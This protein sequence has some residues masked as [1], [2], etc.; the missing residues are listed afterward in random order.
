MIRKH[1]KYRITRLIVLMHAAPKN[2]IGNIQSH[3]M[4]QVTRH[5]PHQLVEMLG[6]QH[7]TK[8]MIETKFQNLALRLH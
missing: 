5:E 6:D 1:G 3:R 7:E 2:I 4:D 8:V